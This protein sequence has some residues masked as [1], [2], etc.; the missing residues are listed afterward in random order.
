MNLIE[1]IKTG[2]PIRRDRPKFKGS[3]GG[4]WIDSRVILNELISSGGGVSY[5]GFQN[6]RP[7]W[8]LDKDDFFADDWEVKE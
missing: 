6:L 7:T 2:K 5:F 8:A 4:G 1:A 3:H